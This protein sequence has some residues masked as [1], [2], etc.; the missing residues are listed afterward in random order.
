MKEGDRM[1]EMK[2]HIDSLVSYH[3]QMFSLYTGK[4][5]EDMKTSIKQHGVI[6]PIIVRP[7]VNGK[8]EILSGHNRVEASKH[9]GMTDI[10]VIIKENLTDE[11]AALIVTESNLIQRAFADLRHSE[12]AFILKNHLEMIKKLNG[13]G[14]RNDLLNSLGFHDGDI[15]SQIAQ[16]KKSRDKVA[17]KY[18]L[19]KDTVMR[20]VRLTKLPKKLL[21]LVDDNK[22]KFIPA[23]ELSWLSIDELNVL[24]EIYE[25]NHYR[26]SQNKAKLLRKEST[27]AKGLLT[28]VDI[29]TI[30]N[31]IPTKNIYR[32]ISLSDEISK[33]LSEYNIKSEKVYEK[34]I[35]LY[36]DMLERGD[37]EDVFEED[38]NIVS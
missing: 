21:E 26:I 34:I 5:L 30:L 13:Q 27:K 28:K 18:H 16:G 36:L 32:N 35:T 20:Y 11:E 12:R 8:Y 31:G 10:P 19:S 2:L 22:I 23:A 24:S 17:E 25:D 4:R 15:E 9:L 7:T 37:I 3:D 38:E 6:S 33:R 1:D 14:K 29:L